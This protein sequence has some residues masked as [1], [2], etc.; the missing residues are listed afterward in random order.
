MDGLAEEMGWPT[1][2]PLRAGRILAVTVLAVAAVFASKLGQGAS[3]ALDA[4]AWESG[5]AGSASAT[6][7]ASPA[8][9]AVDPGSLALRRVNATWASRMAEETDIPRRALV[10]YAAASLAA[11]SSHPDCRLS[12]NTVAAIGLVE[13][14]HGGHDGAVLATDGRVRPVIRG[15]VLDGSSSAAITDSDS[16][17]LDGNSHWDRA[18]GP[19]QFL[20]ST[21]GRWGTDG[22]GDGVADPDQIDD[23]A[24]AAADYLCAAGGDLASSEGWRRA[25]L[26]YN[27][28]GDYLARV[29]EAANRY[30]RESQ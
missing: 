1:G 26:A 9:T 11:R 19:M 28:S 15:P 12:W 23:A 24:L 2:A 3:L 7:G 13:S 4:T 6:V 20:P 16:G 25:I 29:R 30:A 17:V 22:S 27:N 21:W 14:D 8:H 5:I 18:L 10:A